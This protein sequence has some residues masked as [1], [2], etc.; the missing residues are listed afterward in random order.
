MKTDSG[1]FSGTTGASHV[2]RIFTSPDPL[3][4]NLATDIDSEYP[5]MVDDV[6]K[7]VKDSSGRIITDFDIETDKAVIQVKSGKGTGMTKQMLVSK[8]ATT[9]EVI[10]YG[11]KLGKHIVQNLRLLGFKVFTNEK[12]L[13]DYLGGL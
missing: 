8:T 4:G 9:K 6:N 13:I 2:G 11:P 7:I 3:V 5:G 1:L 10:A 12:E